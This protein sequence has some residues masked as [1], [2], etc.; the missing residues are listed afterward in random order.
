MVEIPMGSVQLAPTNQHYAAWQRTASRLFQTGEMFFF[1]KKLCKSI[2]SGAMI[3]RGV[4]LRPQMLCLGILAMVFRSICK[5][6]THA[7]HKT[8]SKMYQNWNCTT[9]NSHIYLA[10]SIG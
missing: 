6:C 8:R 5:S 9:L 10:K 2:V 4:L 3:E 1:F 7:K